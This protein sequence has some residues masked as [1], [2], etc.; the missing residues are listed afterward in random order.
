MFLNA[1]T[2]IGLNRLIIIG[3]K[4]LCI[5][6]ASGVKYVLESKIGVSTIGSRSGSSTIP[7][8]FRDINAGVVENRLHPFI[9]GGIGDRIVWLDKAYKK[10]TVLSSEL[11]CHMEIMRYVGNHTQAFILLIR[12]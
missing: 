3:S 4:C 5:R 12:N 2:K 11:L 9:Y 1:S 7:R 8:E 10:L 6:P